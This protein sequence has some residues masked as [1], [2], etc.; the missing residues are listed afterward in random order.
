[1]L[2]KD[3]A[4]CGGLCMR[5]LWEYSAEKQNK[6]S[7]KTAASR[8]MIFFIFHPR[9]IFKMGLHRSGLFPTQNPRPYRPSLF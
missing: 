9:R 4:L 5:S 2:T 3:A 7:I 1:M 8:N 6:V